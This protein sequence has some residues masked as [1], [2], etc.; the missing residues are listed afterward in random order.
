MYE[1]RGGGDGEPAPQGLGQVSDYIPFPERQRRARRRALTAPTFTSR[2]RREA[3]GLTDRP[4]TLTYARATAAVDG[5]DDE[6]AFASR[7]L[8]H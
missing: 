3:V 8:G 4:A 5:R 2:C 6:L 7:T 1:R